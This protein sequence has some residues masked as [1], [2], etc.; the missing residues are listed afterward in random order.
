MKCFIKIS[1]L[2]GYVSLPRQRFF[3]ETAG[4]TQHSLVANAMRRDTWDAI[5]AHLYLSNNN[6]LDQADKFAKVGLL[7]THLNETFLRYSPKEEFYTFDESM[8]EYFGR[9]GCKQFIRGKPIRFGSKVWCGA[10]THR[11]LTWFK[12]YRGFLKKRPVVNP[13]MDAYFRWAFIWC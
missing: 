12:L 13:P 5:F 1:L 8:C 6:N 4:Y 3:W 11:Y 2:S 9:Q 7:A 10:T